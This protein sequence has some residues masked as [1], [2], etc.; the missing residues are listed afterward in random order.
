MGSI[1]AITN[2][3]GGVGKTT[4][5][6]NLA[7]SLAASERRVLLIDGD[8]Q[9]NASSGLGLTP[10]ALQ[11]SLYDVL[12]DGSD[13]RAAVKRAIHFPRL[14]VLAATPDLAGAEVELVG[15]VGR[16]LVLRRAIE[17]I[18][19]EYDFV[20]VDCPP[21]LGLLTV[22]M[23]SA[24]D[25]LIIPLQCEYFA[26]E[27]LTQL[28]RTVDLVQKRLNPQLR[29][30]GVLLTMYDARLNLSRQVADDAREY[31]GQLV[32]NTV[33]PRNIRLAEAPSFGRPIL[34]Y[35][36][37][38]VGSTA[39]LALA[40]EVIERSGTDVSAIPAVPETRQSESVPRQ[41]TVHASTSVPTPVADA[42]PDAA[43]VVASPATHYSDIAVPE[44]RSLTSPEAYLAGLS[45]EPS[46]S[47][48]VPL[49]P[50]TQSQTSAT[51][52]EPHVDPHVQGVMDQV[53]PYPHDGRREHPTAA[54]SD[55]GDDVPDPR[56]DRLSVADLPAPQPAVSSRPPGL[57]RA[58][59]IDFGDA[60]P[61]E[62]GHSL[63]DQQANLAN[64]PSDTP[65]DR[66]PEPMDRTDEPLDTPPPA[67][68]DDNP[69]ASNAP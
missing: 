10:D 12:I 5:A 68:H 22:N 11:A 16:E 14:D 27:G 53:E 61:S 4:T 28:L 59:E 25:S 46:A 7:A 32:F 66:P 57:E 49:Q 21:S 43:R 50:G 20:F 29:I 6:I 69:A 8:P 58:P 62:G 36:I 65:A 48:E 39:Y 44:V 47:H 41:S 33:I 55:D 9:G 40:K 13:P 51:D 18:R 15:E 34:T 24:A 54:P 38:S 42:E 19:S 23:L 3:K 52:E 31:F 56:V 64:G 26:L 63:A 45:P 35:D 1:I 67:H 37:A 2:Q 30:F 60:V 17:S